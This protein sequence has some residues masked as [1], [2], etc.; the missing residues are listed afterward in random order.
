M[1]AVQTAR[2]EEYLAGHTRPTYQRLKLHFYTQLIKMSGSPELLL[3]KPFP[4]FW[5]LFRWTCLSELL[6]VGVHVTASF[7]PIQ[8]KLLSVFV[9]KKENLKVWVPPG[10]HLAASSCP[11]LMSRLWGTVTSTHSNGIMEWFGLEKTLKIVSSFL[12]TDFNR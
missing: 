7:T 3:I 6:S 12:A 2:L 4:V 5:H 8:G 1:L 10:K 11:I 9:L